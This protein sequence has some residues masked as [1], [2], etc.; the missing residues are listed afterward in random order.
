MESL[1]EILI[2]TKSKLEAR[3][4]QRNA[5]ARKLADQL[6]GAGGGDV[7]GADAT[8]DLIADYRRAVA[9]ELSAAQDY[10]DADRV[11]QDG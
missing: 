7:V 2:A 5:V 6:I 1:D 11:W 3:K 10:A 4:Q 8:A 9:A